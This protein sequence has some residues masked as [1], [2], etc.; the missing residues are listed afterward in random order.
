MDQ[1]LARQSTGYL[2][3]VRTNRNFRNLWI[4]Q[5]IS[6]LGDWFNLIASASLIAAL[7]NSGLAVGSLFVVRMIAPFLVSPIAGVIADRYD[8]RQILIAAD[9]GRALAVCGFL[10]VRESGDVWLLYALTAVQLGMSGFFFPARS[11][12]LPDVVEP[13]FIGPANALS[14]V[15]WS[16]MLALGAALGGFVAGAWGVYTAF[17]IDAVT[18]LVSAAFI[19]QIRLRPRAANRR[20]GR[21][22]A[23]AMGE[24]LAGLAYLG[25]N[26]DL[27]LTAL[28]KAAM[29]LAFGSAME[30]I[31]VAISRDVFVIGIDGGL[32]LGLMYG[33]AGVGS[34]L[35]PVV[36]RY[37]TGDRTA[38][39][40]PALVVGYLIAGVGLMTI[41]TLDSFPVVLSGIFVRA[42]GSGAIWVLS[43]QILLQEL[44]EPV[45]GR[46][47]ATEHA[48]FTL[49]GAGGAAAGGQLL[50]VLGIGPGVRLLALAAIVPAALWLLWLRY[51][52]SAPRPGDGAPG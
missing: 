34:A 32:G 18:F 10:L 25:K 28:H 38:S 24:Y 8:R 49:A 48:L 22:A 42:F 11:A 40:R 39:L 44:P 23:A 26:L 15:T 36:F 7:T 14:S 2:E 31:Q 30:V 35:G 27:G 12:I 37:F 29:V 4:G 16:V 19:A 9:L 52:G 51:T 46:V 45:R 47:F 5:I 17:T 21:S 50:D 20:G 43:S 3:L 1:P 6:L 13:E 41:S 33:M